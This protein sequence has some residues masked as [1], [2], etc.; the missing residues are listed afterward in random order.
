MVTARHPARLGCSAPI[1]RVEIKDAQ[2]P[3][4]PK[5]S[6]S[7]QAEAERER[8]ARVISADGDRAARRFGTGGD[9]ATPVPAPHGKTVPAPHA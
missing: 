1:D 4:S 9:V 5:R 7:R 2:L 3:E 6:M 8:R